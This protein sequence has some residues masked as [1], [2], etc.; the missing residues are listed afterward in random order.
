MTSVKPLIGISGRRW[1][2]TALGSKISVAMRELDVDLHFADYGRSVNLA[3]GVPVEL[4]RDAGVDD[5]LDVVDGLILSGGADVDPAHYGEAPSPDLGVTEPDRDEWEI[6]LYQGARKRG[7]P[8][9]GICRGF[10]IINVIEGGSLN[11]HVE[12]E[13]GAGHPQWDVDGHA[14]THTVEV[15]GGE[16]T[17]KVLSG[18]VP[19]NS[20]H[21]QTV[22]E[23]ASSLIATARAE[24]GVIEGFESTDGSV[25]GV[26]WHPELLHAPDP[27]FSWVVA[28][29]SKRKADRGS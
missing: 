19:V 28:A 5:V 2:A 25:L 11:Q 18:T 1:K 26:Q 27:T 21:H 17:S 20:L 10:Q 9:L 23:L 14:T 12:L 24:D 29:A 22:K 8:V 7:I 4:T 3:G 6:A 15:I 16:V 13:S